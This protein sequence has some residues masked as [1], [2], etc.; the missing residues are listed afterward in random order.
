[1][2]ANPATLKRRRGIAR[3]SLT[4]LKTRVGE[5]EAR[6][7]LSLSLEEARRLLQHLDAIDSDFK[8]NHLALIDAIEDEGE[9]DKEQ[10]ILD[11]HEPFA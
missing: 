4:W 2:A 1:M 3:G 7:D 6:D 11:D 10:G 5:L 8:S 9:L